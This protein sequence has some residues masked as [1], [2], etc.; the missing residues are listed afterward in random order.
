[1]R[2]L[3]AGRGILPNRHFPSDHLPVAAVLEFVD[4]ASQ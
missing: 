3:L 4:P 1:M 2:E